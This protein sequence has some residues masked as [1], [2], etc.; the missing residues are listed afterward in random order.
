MFYGE[1]DVDFLAER[2]A[3]EEVQAIRTKLRSFVQL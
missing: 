1:F 2:Q 3:A